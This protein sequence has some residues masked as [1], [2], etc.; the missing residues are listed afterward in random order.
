MPLRAVGTQ[1]VI[2]H[3]PK[4]TWIVLWPRLPLELGGSLSHWDATM[5]GDPTTVSSSS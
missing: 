3:L 5:K 2:G 1:R 4:I